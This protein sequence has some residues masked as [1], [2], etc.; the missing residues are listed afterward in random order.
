M[1]MRKFSEDAEQSSKKETDKETSG[2]DAERKVKNPVFTG[3][4]EAL[5]EAS[6]IQS[7]IR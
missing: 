3:E 1:S 4:H 6:G 2:C 5:M 7:T